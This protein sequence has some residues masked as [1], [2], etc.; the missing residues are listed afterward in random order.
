M[1]ITIGPSDAGHWLVLLLIAA[2][3][4]LVVEL[5]RR[6]AIPLGF[7]GEIGFAA[8][9]AWIGGDLLPAR[10]NIPALAQPTFE[11]VAV[12]PAAIG[13]LLVG[14]LWG[15]MGGRGRRRY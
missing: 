9:G 8:L 3:A 11:N 14:F 1:T 15:L 10:L 4:G 6:G 5:A 2:L 12:I 13:A 7:V